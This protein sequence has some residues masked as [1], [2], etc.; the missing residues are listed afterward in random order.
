MNKPVPIRK[1]DVAVEYLTNAL[2][3]YK[4]KHFYSALTLGGAAEEILGKAIKHLPEKFVGISLPR[5]H[6]LDAEIAKERYADEIFE[7]SKR[8]DKK[9]T[10]SINFSKN[11]A[12]HFGDAGEDELAFSDPAIEAGNVLL[13]AIENCRMVHPALHD[14]FQFE[15]EEIEVYQLTQGPFGK[16]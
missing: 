9:I 3:H 13:R 12:K 4:N 10:E 8:T 16:A 5:Q 6:A 15:Q 1:V 14:Q 2:E 7:P 11:S